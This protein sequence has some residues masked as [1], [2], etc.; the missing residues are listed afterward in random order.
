MGQVCE[1]SADTLLRG[2]TVYRFK[3]DSPKAWLTH[4]GTVMMPRR[5]FQ[6]DRGGRSWVPLDERCGMVD[7]FMMPELERATSFLCARLAPTE[8]EES[9]AEVLPERPSRTAIQ[10]VLSKVGQCTEDHAAEL[11]EA[12]ETTAPL[13]PDGDTLVVSWDGVTSPCASRA[14]AR[15]SGG[16]ARGLGP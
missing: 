8:V 1:T 12:I 7:R 9:L 14:P 5:L 16:T 6:P 4:W 10:H 2:G 11:E 13:D 15:T 3:E